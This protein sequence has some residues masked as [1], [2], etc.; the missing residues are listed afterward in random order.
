ML[1]YGYPEIR[2]LL[3][4]GSFGLERESLRVLGDG[5]LSHTRNPLGESAHV[6]RDFCENQTE[7][8]TDPCPSAEEAV[9][10]LDRFTAN[11]QRVLADLPE[12]E[13]LWPFSNPPYIKAEN[14]IPIAR[15][16][17]DLAEKTE[18][19]RYLSAR[20]GRYLM[21]LSGIHVNY[22]FSERLLRAEFRIHENETRTNSARSVKSTRPEAGMAQTS[23]TKAGGSEP[24]RGMSAGQAEEARFRKFR[25]QFYVELAEKAA[26]SGWILT[27]LTAASPLGDSSFAVEGVTGEDYF[28]GM[29]SIRC[30]ELGYWNFFTPVLDY[31]DIHS[32]ADSIESYVTG[33]VLRAPSE[34][35]YPVRLKPRGKNTLDNLRSGGV[36]HIELRMFD[37]NPL[38]FSGVAVRDVKFAQLLLIYLAAGPAV[39]ADKNAQ[40]MAVRNFKSAARYD[41]RTVRL[42]STDGN[43]MSMHA[44]GLRLLHDMKI[45][46]RD[47]DQDVQCVLD[48]ELEKFTD[49]KRRYAAAVKEKYAGGF[50]KKGLALARQRQEESLRSLREGERNV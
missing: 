23:R 35:Y 36:S 40:I 28:P 2:D 13:L 17:G 21:T 12:P 1:H 8:N 33:G 48:F 10:E 25:D 11:I 16:D 32:Y 38:A 34:L 7:V 6:T 47:C 42:A 45:F 15:F 30:S 14:D 41:L 5:T 31:S 44:A 37:L 27:A 19:R 20:Y 46:F 3:F 9:R 39:R 22:S 49:P 43:E 29:A 50:V 4:H 18:Y 24:M 26:V